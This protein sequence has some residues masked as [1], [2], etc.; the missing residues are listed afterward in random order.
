MAGDWLKVETCTPDKPEVIGIADILGIPPAHAFGS[1]FLIWRWF[2]QHTTEGNASFVT[3]VTV[4][5]LSG[6]AGFADAMAKVGWLV[7]N[8]DGVVSLPHFDRH[9]GETAKQ[10]SLTAKRV[11]KSKA[12][13]NGKGNASG[14][15]DSNATVTDNAL[16]REEKRRENIK[17][18]IP[19]SGLN[20]IA[21]E[22]W[23]SYRQK[24]N[25]PIKPAS[26]E[27]AMKKLA[28]LGD[29]QGEAIEDAIANGYQG[30]FE[31]KGK[32]NGSDQRHERRKQFLESITGGNTDTRTIEGTA[33]EVGRGNPEAHDAALRLP[34]SGSLGGSEG[35]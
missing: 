31:P 17:P 1:L 15:D 23:L 18:P 25:K 10:R 32:A 28:K 27:A 33:S 26:L 7:V 9:N 5:R 21:W 11:A 19:P 30:F 35:N 22:T 12:K 3:K 24:I 2:D 34:V 20:L 4:D 16:P 29:R 14:N 13:S 8:A 6:N